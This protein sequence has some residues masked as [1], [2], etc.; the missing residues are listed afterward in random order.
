MTEATKIWNWNCNLHC[1]CSCFYSKLSDIF[2]DGRLMDLIK[3]S[4]LLLSATLIIQNSFLSL[5]SEKINHAVLFWEKQYLT[6]CRDVYGI[7]PV[8][9]QSKYG[10][11]PSFSRILNKNKKRSSRQKEMVALFQNTSRHLVL[12]SKSVIDNLVDKELNWRFIIS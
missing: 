1:Q 8:L 7:S 9:S 6:W 5:E 10:C 3:L 11:L 4:Y 2:K 12:L